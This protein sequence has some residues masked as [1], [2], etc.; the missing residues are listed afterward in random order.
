MKDKYKYER[1]SIFYNFIKTILSKKTATRFP[2]SIFRF[3]GLDI[4][5][6]PTYLVFKMGSLSPQL[7]WVAEI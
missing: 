3:L 7:A 1:I 4:C 6:S 5:Y 2:F